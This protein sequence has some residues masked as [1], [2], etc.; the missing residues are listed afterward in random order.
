VTRFGL[1]LVGAAGLAAV[2]GALLLASW[3]ERLRGEAPTSGPERP[4]AG[5]NRPGGPRPRAA[6]A[7][8]TTPPVASDG[9]PDSAAL[10]EELLARSESGGAASEADQAE[11]EALEQALVARGERAAEMLARR[12]GR[13]GLRG[14][15]RDRL[16]NV[17][18]RLPGT[19]A[20]GRLAEEARR[21]PQRSTRSLAMDA[22]AE[23]R[24]E[25]ALD[26]LAAIA[27]SDPELP[28]RPLIVGPR[29]PDDPSMEL[30]DEAVFTPRMKAMMALA[31]TEDP[32]AAAVLIEI[33]R[34]GPDESLRMQA[35]RFLQSFRSEARA[36]EALR[37]AAAFDPSA[38][39]RLAALHA[40]EGSLDPE[41]PAVLAGI[42]A[43][44]RDAGVRALA[45]QLQA[46][47][48]H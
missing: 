25:R 26:T 45:Q 11:M 13:G 3:R 41:L 17:L 2:G 22:L 18:R 29:Q 42:I 8:E 28:A 19:A 37:V 48:D 21:G 15:A 32:R 46:N 12:L 10:I 30:P 38:F 33:L 9:D 5:L 39:V 40:L 20:E 1:G 27:R 44:D 43:A 34:T 4:V 36:A 31:E 47:L 16:F 14:E 35:A 7:A 6:P 23:R 24:S